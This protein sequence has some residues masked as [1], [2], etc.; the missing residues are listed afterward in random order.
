M[1][2]ALSVRTCVGDGADER[3]N[4]SDRVNV[5]DPLNGSVRVN[6]AV[7]TK[8]AVALSA[9]ERR[10]TDLANDGEAPNA[11]ETEPARV[12]RKVTLHGKMPEGAMPEAAKFAE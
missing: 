5:G 10:A 6:G 8:A 2:A 1:N 7:R 3:P 11:K 12:H 9:A 4:P